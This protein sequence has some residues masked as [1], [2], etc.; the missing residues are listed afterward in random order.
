MTIFFFDLSDIT[1]S[2]SSISILNF[3]KEAESADASPGHGGH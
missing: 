1:H 2:C 3:I